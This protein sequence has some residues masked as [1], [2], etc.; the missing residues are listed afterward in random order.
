MA[1]IDN[2]ADDEVFEMATTSGYTS[3]HRTSLYVDV[4]ARFVMFRQASAQPLVARRR[5]AR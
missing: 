3:G 4:F 2:F 1:E 5:V